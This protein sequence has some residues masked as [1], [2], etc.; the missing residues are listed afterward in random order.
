MIDLKTLEEIKLIQASSQLVSKTLG[1]LAK[2]IYPGVNTLY[3]D[4]LAEEFIRDYGGIPAFLGL[5]GFPN[6]ICVSPNEQVVHGIPNKK[7]LKNGDIIS[8]DC[9]VLMNGYYG[10]NAYTFEVGEVNSQIRNFIKVSKE[11]LYLGISYLKYGNHIG[12]IGYNIQNNVEKYGY[13]VVRDLVGHGIGKK[14]HEYPY[15]PNYGHNGE[16]NK[17][18]EGLVI[19]IET[20]INQGTH[21]V[22]FSKDGWTIKTMD[23]KLSSHFEHNVAL[24]K[25]CPI[26]LSTFK[27]I[28]EV[29]GIYTDEEFNFDHKKYGI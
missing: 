1:M 7:P 18:E 17:L 12:D 22:K 9:G 26:L 8:I 21:K 10:D 14:L 3:L 25:G 11:S 5:Y 19:A 15:I 2:E 23:K 6:T 28:Y 20:M 29:L 13:S 16:G 24:F 27:Y 4:H